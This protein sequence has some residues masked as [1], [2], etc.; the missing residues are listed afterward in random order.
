VGVGLANCVPLIFSAAARQSEA[1]FGRRIAAVASAGY[2]GLFAG[3]PIIARKERAFTVRRWR[4]AG[5]HLAPPVVIRFPG[6]KGCG[7]FV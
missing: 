3:P 7:T 4:S 6:A 1:G 5:R 2:F